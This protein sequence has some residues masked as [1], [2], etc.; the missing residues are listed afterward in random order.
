MENQPN[1]TTLPSMIAANDLHV[2][3]IATLPPAERNSILSTL[4]EAEAEALIY[5]WSFWAR[6]KQ[7]APA[8]EWET[9]LI[10]AGRG[11][12]KTRTGA[13]WIRDQIEQQGKRRLALVA[14]T[15]ADVRDVMVE[16]ESGILAISPPW[17]R[18]HYEPSKR[19]L[20]WP[21]G[22]IATTYSGDKPDQLRGPQHDG[23]WCDE[24]AAWRYPESFDQ[25]QFGLRL[26]DNPQVVVT[27]TPRP[28]QVIRD[29]IKDTATV[30]TSGS[31]YENVANLAPRALDR[32]R[33]KYEN[34]RLGEQELYAK[35]LDDNPFALW[36]RATIDQLRVTQHP[37][38][39][40]IVVAIDPQAKKS[41]EKRD[42][43]ETS[44]TG[45]VVAGISA[46]GHGYI[47]DDLTIDGTPDQW[48]RAAVTGYHKF[49]ADRIVAEVN[50]GG[51]MVEFTVKT[52][53]PGVP[54]K[55]LHASRGK[56]TR[57]E[58]VAALY[59]QSKVHHVGMFAELED[60]MCQWVPGDDSPDR[61]DALV[62]ALTELMLAG[63]G[64]VTS[65]N[66]LAILNERG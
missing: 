50:Q 56:H 61:M 27:T 63:P 18:P 2:S 64:E 15:A 28:I 19:R 11:F 31:T 32:L 34:T 23:A 33:R 37:A 39:T 29:L 25:L 22:A 20:I 3:S 65:S 54:F 9:W 49:E 24:L 26:G 41:S 44:E 17:N 10:M 58:P 66:A 60:Q 14:R 7:L 13:E 42:M 38:L 45:I 62:W 12:G 46:D 36:K 30:I 1:A 21:N 43:D 5:D 53:E 59:E 48:G 40:R 4:T 16:G 8:G 35:L 51:D 47:L 6:D 52:I 55:Q 57:A